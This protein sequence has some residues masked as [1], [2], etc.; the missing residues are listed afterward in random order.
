MGAHGIP[1]ED[2][3]KFSSLRSRRTV[4][5][6]VRIP[7]RLPHGGGYWY[8]GHLSGWLDPAMFST[9][10]LSTTLFLFLSVTVGMAWVFGVLF[11]YMSGVRLQS[12][13]SGRS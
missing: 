7:G 9:S 13:T 12:P 2:A 10:I 5:L 1:A 8:N 6:L 11:L 3:H 4:F